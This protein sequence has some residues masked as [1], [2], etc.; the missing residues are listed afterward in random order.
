MRKDDRAILLA[1][2]DSHGG[3]IKGLL[4]PEVVLMQFDEEGNRVFY[5]PEPTATAKYLWNIF[6]EDAYSVKQLAGKDPIV[7]FHMG[8][9]GQGKK[10]VKEWVSTRQWDQV[11]IAVANWEPMLALPTLVSIRL[12][13]GTPSHD[14]GEGSLT[15]NVCQLLR[16]ERK[17]VSVE[18]VEHGLATIAGV[19]VDY[20]HKGPW[21]GSR[22]WLQGNVALYYLKSL[23]ADELD[24][25]NIPPDLVIRA[26]YHSY[27]EMY[28]RKNGYR[29]WITVLP[30]YCGMSEYAVSATGSAFILKNGMVAYEIVNGKLREIHPLLHTLDIRTKETII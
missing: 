17:D 26:H 12:V 21:T 4:N 14:F 7:A 19:K 11:A 18:A 2:G 22:N 6:K 15:W 30:S 1:W 20:S 29:S 23:Q 3:H 27:V 9:Q 24:L 5:S 25:G 16:N 10:Y 13:T 8:D 28:N